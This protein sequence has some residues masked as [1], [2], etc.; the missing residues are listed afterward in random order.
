MKISKPGVVIPMTFRIESAPA[1]D[2]ATYNGQLSN[3]GEPDV[4]PG[5]A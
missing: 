5:K 3:D 2:D 1:L 4:Y